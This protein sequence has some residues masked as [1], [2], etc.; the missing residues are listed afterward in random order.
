MN[1]L[2]NLLH[3]F[4]PHPKCAIRRTQFRT[5]MLDFWIQG[6]QQLLEQES[7]IDLPL[8]AVVNEKRCH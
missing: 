1:V 8:L 2:A 6:Q 3:M 7:D 4:Y 5:L